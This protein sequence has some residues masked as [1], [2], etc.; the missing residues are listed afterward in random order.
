MI[1]N[2]WHC[3]FI[4][5]PHKY[6]KYLVEQYRGSNRSNI[7]IIFYKKKLPTVITEA[8]FF[9]KTGNSV[10]FYFSNPYWKIHTVI[11]I[12]LPSNALYNHKS[13]KYVYGNK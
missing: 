5:L 12:L 9:E 10:I 2:N 11:V 13:K 8:L 3:I 6:K 1:T 4:P 7:R